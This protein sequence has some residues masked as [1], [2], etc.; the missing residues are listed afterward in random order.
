MEI[1]SP[2]TRRVDEVIKL[3]AYERRAIG[4]YWLVDPLLDTV[5]VYRLRRGQFDRVIERA[6][7]KNDVLTTPFLPGLTIDLRSLFR[8]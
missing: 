1:L 2:S 5:K 6:A 7:D 4:E 8:P 3:Q